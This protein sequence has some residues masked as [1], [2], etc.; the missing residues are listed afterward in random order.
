MSALIYRSAGSL[1]SVSSLSN[2]TG[3]HQLQKLDGLT[4]LHMLL[5]NQDICYVAM[6]DY[7]NFSLFK[8]RFMT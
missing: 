5:L 7:A 6:T 2:M 1:R 3:T 4:L 8:T